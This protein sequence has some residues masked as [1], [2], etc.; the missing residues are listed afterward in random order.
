MKSEGR[1]GAVADPAGSW[2]GVLFMPVWFCAAIRNYTE[3]GGAI[4]TL[5][6][7]G[8]QLVLPKP[9][10]RLRK[11]NRGFELSNSAKMCDRMHSLHRMRIV[12]TGII[13]LCSISSL[14][15][16]DTVAT[17]SIGPRIQFATNTYN[18]GRQI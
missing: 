18:Y 10:P 6:A 16:A 1:G 15:A 2:P 9:A 14:S 4:H 7:A 8:C 12:L 17:N 11:I 3:A 5:R 13:L